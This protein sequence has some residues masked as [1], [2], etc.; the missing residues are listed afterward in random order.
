MPAKLTKEKF[1]EKARKIHGDKYDYSKVEYVNNRTKVEIICPIHGSFYITPDSHLRSRE[2][3]LCGTIRAKMK[4]RMEQDVFIKK[5]TIVHNGKYDYSEV[6][7]ENT[8]TKVKIICPEHG[9][10]WQTPHHHLH[11]IGCPK[12][13]ANNIS[14]NKLFTILKENFKDAVQQYS[15]SFLKENG[16]KQFIDIFIPSKNVGIEYQGRQ[17]FTAISKFG[18]EKE[19]KLTKQ[20]DEKKYLKSKENGIKILY[21]SYERDLPETYI[22]EIF[23]N[24]NKLIKKINEL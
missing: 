5:A 7:Y 3:K 2:C 13:G 23:K 12:C 11:G 15:P 22:D 6:K 8:D 20:R 18:G 16:H 9:E 19:F 24:E 14:E 21:F 10:F 1:I 4:N 17:H